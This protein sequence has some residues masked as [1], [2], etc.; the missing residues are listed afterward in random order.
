MR[1][2]VPEEELHAYCDGELSPIQR[3]EIAD[4]LLGC[5]I[6]RAQYGEVDALRV[7][8][9]SLLDRAVPRRSGAAAARARTRR[10]PLLGPAAVAAAGLL[11]ATGAW[12]AAGHRDA[13]PQLAGAFVTPTL[14]ASNADQSS[15]VTAGPATVLRRNL[16]LASRAGLHPSVVLGSAPPAA[17]PGPQF[18]R[19]TEVDPV[20]SADWDPVSPDTAIADGQGSFSKLTG[21]PVTAIRVHHTDS[22]VRPTFM[23]RQQLPD[24]RSVWVLE[25]PEDDIGGVSQTLEA[26]GLSLSMPLRARPDYLDNAAGP[27]H[28]IRMVMIAAYLSPD[29]LNT[30]AG[31]LQP[32]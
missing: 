5:L 18:D 20:E 4:H 17:R 26:T 31:R 21:M 14:V 9:K 28:T 22:G 2:H 7:R 29:S 23:V 27:A 24:G 1:P 12:L 11:V 16:T 19:A 8:V 30:L 15:S 32:H 6:C 10:S 3:A 25:G 13:A